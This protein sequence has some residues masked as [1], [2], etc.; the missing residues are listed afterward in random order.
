MK[1]AVEEVI[2]KRVTQLC[3]VINNYFNNLCLFFFIL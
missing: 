2:E 3:K 1:I